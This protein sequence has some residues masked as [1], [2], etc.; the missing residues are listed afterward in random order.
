MA[1]ETATLGGG[2]FWC[3]EAAFLDLK[4][5]T[6]VV[7]GYAGG[8]APNPSYQQVCT[9]ST[10]HAEVVQVT[11]DNAAI[12]YRTILEVFFTVHDPTTLNAQGA[13]VGTQYRSVI[14]WHTDAQRETALAVI[15]QLT[16][17][18]VWP[19]AIVTEVAPLPT[20][21]PAEDYHQNYY[22]RNPYQGYCQA[23][24]SPKLGKLRQKHRELL[25]A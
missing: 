6:A 7:S 2:C 15:A 3:V 5:V 19:N 11:F 16:R 17:E 18:G 14:Y 21:Y 24:I 20:F 10:G 13:D 25:V 8:A 1:S 23:V 22:R 12:D 9:G 4:G